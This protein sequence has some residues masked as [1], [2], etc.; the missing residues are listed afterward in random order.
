LKAV[1]K[2]L[3]TAIAMERYGQEYY[4]WFS[5]SISDRKGKS[6]MK[7]LARDEKEHEEIMSG[8]YE[9]EC[10]KAPPEDIDIDIG[11]KDVKKVFSQE[12][13]KGEKDIISKILQ[14]GIGI[15]QKSID[16]YS[17]ESK[18]TKSVKMK[19]LLEKLTEIEKGH[20]ALLEETL[21]HMKQDGAWWGY[22][23]I[24]DG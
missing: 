16:F 13:K 24:L 23:P 15:E 19:K 20:K 22:T 4:R 5:D 1:E 17:S 9:K 14:L 12:R 8:E 21:F 18:K 7:G 3:L 2:M 10:G 6:M 11:G